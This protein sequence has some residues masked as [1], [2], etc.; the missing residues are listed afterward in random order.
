MT[1]ENY[2]KPMTSRAA[3]GNRVPVGYQGNLLSG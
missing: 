1:T 2:R 3:T